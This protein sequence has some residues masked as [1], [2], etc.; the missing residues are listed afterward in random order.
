M[1]LFAESYTEH[2]GLASPPSESGSQTV[3]SSHCPN[4]TLKQIPSI[5]TQRSGLGFTILAPLIVA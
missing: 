4:P 2:C 3:V 5:M 1:V